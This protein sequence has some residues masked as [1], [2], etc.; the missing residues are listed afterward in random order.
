MK[1]R[2]TLYVSILLFW[3]IL[4]ALFAPAVINEYHFAAGHSIT[5]QALLTCNAIFISYFWLNGAKDL[6]YVFWLYT[7]R[8]RL[9]KYTRS[10]RSEREREREH[11]SPYCIAPAMISNPLH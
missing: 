8:M 1:K 9:L 4:I 2:S 10:V 7:N 11:A 5:L 6:I 3:S